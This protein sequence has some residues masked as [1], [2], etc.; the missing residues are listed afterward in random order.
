MDSWT[1]FSQQITA[2]KVSN[3][4]SINAQTAEISQ[5]MWGTMVRDAEGA[6][7]VLNSLPVISK[8]VL[9]HEYMETGLTT[10]MSVTRAHGQSL[11]KS[12]TV[13]AR[14]L[15]GNIDIIAGANKA[16]REKK[17]LDK[18][19]FSMLLS[20]LGRTAPTTFTPSEA[21]V[22]EMGDEMA[23]LV[24]NDSKLAINTTNVNVNIK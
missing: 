10:P 21:F 23:K 19:T 3:A 1:M 7:N 4:Y 24:A 22:F 20:E 14:F 11:A 2:A 16:Q 12:F 6:I 9:A 8:V 18:Y 15:N 5:P 17:V 13:V